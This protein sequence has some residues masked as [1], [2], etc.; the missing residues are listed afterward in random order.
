[1]ACCFRLPVELHGQT[2]S[3]AFDQRG[4]ATLS[5]GNVTLINLNSGLGDAFS[6]GS[7]QLGNTD[8]WGETGHSASWDQGTKT[9]VWRWDWGSV[10]CQYA[11]AL[12]RG[13][14]RMILT[15]RNG[16]RQTLKGITIYPFGLQFPKLPGGFGAPNFPQFHNN[17]D[18]PNLIAA[19]LRTQTVFFED[20]GTKPL[21]V[22]LSPSG[23]ANH[24]RLQVGT[25]ND[26]SE[27]FLA[28]AAP[29][30]RTV[31]P[32]ESEAI[33]I[34]LRTSAPSQAVQHV[35]AEQAE[36]YGKAWPQTLRWKDRRPIGELFLSN[37]T[38][39][40]LP[41]SGPNPRNYTIANNIDVRTGPGRGNF[42]KNV[43][44]YADRA[45]KILESA[46]AQGV[47]VWD[48][49]G[50][51]YPQP[52]TSYIGD[53]TLLPKLAPEMDAIADQFF[54][55]FTAAGLRCGLTIRPQ[56]IDI[57]AA[58]PKQADV[59]TSRQAENII[60]KI[61]YAN[62]RWG[63]SLFYVDS[64]G[65]PNDASA[66]SVFQDVQRALPDV[67][68]IPE[69]IWPRY[70]AYA[71]PLASFTAPYKPLHTPAWVK[72]VWPDAFTV[73]YIGDAPNHDLRNNP[74]NP[75]QWNEFV[76]AVRQGDILTFRA[77][78]NDQP[79]NQQVNAV[80][81]AAQSAGARSKTSE[82]PGH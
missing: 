61:R 65:G 55:K 63:C 41:D 17:L 35:R 7:Y 60:S 23:R 1:M 57:S 82:K 8:G 29:I 64:N 76:E 28:R 48:L 75:N 81:Q 80:Y 39:E 27:G 16:S 36:R 73:T 5:V 79:L 74:D 26:Q 10:S 12:D 68:V 52:D 69:N 25:I 49:E 45:L 71:A 11:P 56:S 58:I 3:A 19:D 46:H 50:Q 2:L 59:P 62:K 40:P 9:I 77:W 4:V 43:L 24:Y 15:V 72:H 37:P 78:F 51:Q 47:I 66:P 6:V 30:E 34:T 70:Y 18:A 31:G 13:E 33:T 38:T 53:P 22:G 67:L 42:A 32:G 21:Y 54:R 44:A 20:L 14:L